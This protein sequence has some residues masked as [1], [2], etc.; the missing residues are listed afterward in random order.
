MTSTPSLREGQH[1]KKLTFTFYTTTQSQVQ[2]NSTIL[3]HYNTKT[4]KP[5]HTSHIMPRNGD[6]ASDNG[7]IEGQDI[8]HGTSGDVMSPPSTA[9]HSTQL[10]TVNR[11]LSN[12]RKTT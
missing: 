7:P 6:G 12:T 4:P 1:R 3:Q 9:Q 10:T 2:H 5:P 11:P 8:T